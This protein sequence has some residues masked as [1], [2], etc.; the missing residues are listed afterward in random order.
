MLCRKR[1]ISKIFIIVSNVAIFESI[2]DKVSS[3]LETEQIF[4]FT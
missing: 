3:D 1:S 4:S 2:T